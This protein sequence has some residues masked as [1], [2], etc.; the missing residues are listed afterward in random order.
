MA[1][2][3]P[4]FNLRAK[5]KDVAKE[6]LIIANDDLLERVEAE[7][8]KQITPEFIEKIRSDIRKTPKAAI[9]TPVSKPT[10]T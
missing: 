3:N 2:P 9:P 6:A 10:A 8:E 1:K 7:I 4:P 5:I